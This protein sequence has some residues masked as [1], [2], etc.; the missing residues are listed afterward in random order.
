M[1]DLEKHS[2]W[3]QQYVEGLSGSG[4]ALWVRACAVGPG[5]R[6]GVVGE[7]I[8]HSRPFPV[9]WRSWGEG[10]WRRGASRVMW[11]RKDGA[12]L[13]RWSFPPPRVGSGRAAFSILGRQASGEWEAQKRRPCHISLRL[14][15]SGSET[16]RY[17]CPE[18]SWAGSTGESA[19]WTPQ[20]CLEPSGAGRSCPRVFSGQRSSKRRRPGPAALC[21]TPPSQDS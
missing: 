18:C 3:E 21:N 8:L 7:G 12:G 16:W 20:L 17:F 2:L 15:K 9:L 14:E 4:H 6:C 5:M 13:T 11:E 10:T 19:R 1:G